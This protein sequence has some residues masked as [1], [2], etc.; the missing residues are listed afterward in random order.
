VDYYETRICAD[1]AGKTLLK[2][3]RSTDNVATW[4]ESV[5]P[6]VYYL[7]VRS[8]SGNQH[9]GF[10]APIAFQIIDKMEITAISPA[11]NWVADP[12]Q[13]QLEFRWSD[14]NQ[15]E[16]LQL[17]L[18]DESG[19]GHPWLQMPISGS[20]QSL[21]VPAD[22]HDRI[23]WRVVA[24]EIGKAS[25]A[26]SFYMPQLLNKPQIL[27][28]GDG[29]E[30]DI[31]TTEKLSLS[32]MGSSD[33]NQYQISMF[34]IDGTRD[35]KVQNWQ[36][37]LQK[38]SITQLKHYGIGNFRWA[39]RAVKLEKN[40]PVAQSAPAYGYFSI[41]QSHALPPPVVHRRVLGGQQ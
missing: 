29:M 26:K 6:A 11:E 4:V 14:P 16:S 19:F 18:S 32:W 9:S 7:Q 30:L 41:K 15:A 37:V 31:N 38:L 25:L 36:T 8:V 28:P 40:I 23:Y 27:A 13:R 21:Q 35:V 33:A 34:G 5:P 20:R 1:P 12:D 17:Q 22:R 2:A 24:P 10:S 3:S 39:I